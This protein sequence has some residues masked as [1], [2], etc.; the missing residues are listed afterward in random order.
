MTRVI[1]SVRINPDGRREWR[2]DGLLHRIDG[3]AIERANGSKEWWR[4]G[5]RHRDDGPAVEGVGATFWRNGV[6]YWIPPCREWWQNGRLHREDGPA[7]EY[8]EGCHILYRAWYREGRLHR[9]N[10]PAVETANGHR[11]WWIEGERRYRGR[12][13]NRNKLRSP[14]RPKEKE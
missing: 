11:E 13:S 3:P 10:G 6:I 5:L 8:G 14:R 2:S 1:A 7:I 12:Q 9:E 4:D